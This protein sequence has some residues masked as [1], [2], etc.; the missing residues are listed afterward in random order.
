M[1]PLK[2]ACYAR[3]EKKIRDAVPKEYY[4]LQQSETALRPML[5]RQGYRDLLWWA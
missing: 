4:F 2:E 3:D 5:E 1:Y